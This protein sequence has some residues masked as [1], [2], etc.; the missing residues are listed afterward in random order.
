MTE[1]SLQNLLKKYR[2]PKHIQAHMLKVAL[3]SVFIGKKIQE[4]G[5]KVDLTKLRQ[6]AL[7][8]DMMKLCDFKELNLQYFDPTETCTAEDL[9]FWR[10]L[11]KS[12]SSKGHI[13][14]AY[15]VLKELGENELAEI[16]KK[17]R[18]ASLIDNDKPVTWEE[19]ILYYA[20]KRVRHDQIV[21]IAER[22]EDGQKRYF[23][24][25]NLPENDHLVEN[26][27]YEL[28][29]E[30]LSKAKLKAEEITEETIKP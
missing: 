6:A 29:K 20:D 16:V 30:L 3:V 1:E 11:I 2:V 23:P 8:H 22:L 27:L 26:A 13:T 7:L 21:S 24:E 14:A 25:G 5:E 10:D 4:T 17:H 15:E 28:E 9:Q 19:K 18:F 12:C